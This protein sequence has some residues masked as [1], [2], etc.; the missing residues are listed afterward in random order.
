MQRFFILLTALSC[1]SFSLFSQSDQEQIRSV[2]NTFIDGTTFNYPDSIAGAFFPGTRM[3]LYTGTEQ[4]RVMTSEDYAALYSRRPA[5]TKN[6][7]KGSITTIEVVKDV[8]YAKLEFDIPFFGNRYYDLLLLKKIAGEWKIIAKCTAAEPIPKTPEQMVAKPAKE[9]VIE[10][11]NRPWSIAFISEDDVIIAEKDGD[12]LRI[13]LSTK[14]HTKIAG[15][16]KDKAGEIRVDTTEHAQGVFPAHTHGETHSFNSGW[17]QVLLDPD[18][19]NNSYLYLSYA[20]QNSEL[21]STVKVIRGK[22]NGSKLAEVET[23]FLAEPYSH[24]LFHY[25]GGMLFGPDGKLYITVGERNFYEYLNPALPLSQD[26]TDRRGKIFR[27]N[28]DG[29]IPADN[30]DFGNT[31]VRGLYATGIRASQGLALDPAT[32]RIWFSEHGTKQGDEINIL[33]A[34]SNYGWPYKTS[35][36][37]RTQDYKPTFDSTIV[38]TEPAYFWDHTVAPTGLTFYSGNEFPLWKGNLIVPGLSKG[39]LWRMIIEN[40]TIV[41]AEE[42]F[43]DSRV[44]LRKA[45]L[46]PRGQ[47]YL[48][49][50]EENGKLQKVINAH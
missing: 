44:R 28:A 34:G 7:R 30:P 49:T 31:A 6:D 47:L 19:E 3:F 32:N 37:Y 40:D 33:A 16:P 22:L 43:I 18:F 42:L 26:V 1:Y 38:F 2:L 20:A 23:I 21:A 36:N 4:M 35:G 41:G 50:D 25:G 5:G 48:L 46:S 29:S 45:A 12:V 14:V 9:V 13:N 11:L 10:N 39:S 24:G 27:I 17:F 15:L 8:A